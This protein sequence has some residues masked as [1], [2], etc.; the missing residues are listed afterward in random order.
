MVVVG[1]DPAT[2]SPR[3]LDAARADPTAADAAAAR[4]ARVPSSSG[5]ARRRRDRGRASSRATVR[6]VDVRPQ[7]LTVGC[8]GPERGGDARD[9]RP[10]GDDHGRDPAGRRRRSRDRDG[11]TIVRVDV[12]RVAIRSPGPLPWR[13]RVAG[14]RAR[15]AIVA[16]PSRWRA[17]VLARGLLVDPVDP[18]PAPIRPRRRRAAPSDGLDWLAMLAVRDARLGTRGRPRRPPSADVYHGHDLTGLP[19]A[20]AAAAPAADRR[21]ARLRQ[22]RDLPRVRRDR[23]AAAL[24]GRWLGRLERRWAAGAAALVTVNPAIADEL[25]ASGSRSER[26]R[27]R[28]QLPA[29]L[30]RRADRARR[31]H[32]R[33]DRHPG[34]RADRPLSRRAS[35]AAAGWSSWPRRCS[36]PGSRRVHSRLPRA[37]GRSRDERRR[38]SPPSRGSAAGSTCSTAVRPRGRRRGS[39]RPTSGRCRSSR[40]P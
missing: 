18:R 19:A 11:F 7:R 9:R 22:P 29:A 14:G 35:A 27:R 40:R 8:P 12:P 26:L 38:R 39:P 4:A 6:V 15:W 37:T 31:P 2:G 25:G 13:I 32:P 10:R 30:G 20:V 33:R 3:Q 1:L 5:A 17:A 23:G 21:A 36:S 24:G 34:R 28:P 16:G